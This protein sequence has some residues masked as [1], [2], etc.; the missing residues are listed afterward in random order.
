MADLRPPKRDATYWSNLLPE[1]YIFFWDASNMQPKVI[2]GT[3]R[4]KSC[5]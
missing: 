2:V 3:N 4:D 5:A 1:K